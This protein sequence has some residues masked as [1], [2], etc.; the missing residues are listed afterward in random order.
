MVSRRE[1]GTLFG[2]F[3]QEKALLGASPWLWNLREPSDN[4]RLKLY[5]KLSP[6]LLSPPVVWPR[7]ENMKKPWVWIW[8]VKVSS[9]IAY[10]SGPGSATSTFAPPI[11]HQFFSPLLCDLLPR[12][13]LCCRVTRLNKKFMIE[14]S[15]WVNYQKIWQGWRR[16]S[17][18]RECLICWTPCWCRWPRHRVHLQ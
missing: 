6:S 8:R 2:A 7:G 17:K 14:K 3:Y 15:F 18:P 10:R 12:P 4:L 5:Y 9:N 1:I 11:Q 13:A 16:Q